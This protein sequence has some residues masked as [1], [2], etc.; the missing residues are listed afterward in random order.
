[1]HF[2]QDFDGRVLRVSLHANGV[3]P[4]SPSSTARRDGRDAVGGMAM[5]SAQDHSRCSC[6][7]HGSGFVLCSLDTHD[8]CAAIY[9]PAPAASTLGKLEAEGE[10]LLFEDDT[11]DVDK[12]SGLLH[13]CRLVVSIV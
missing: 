6:F 10:A 13:I 2:D 8:G 5:A 12:P 7:F 9:V 4:R 11:R 3:L 1:M